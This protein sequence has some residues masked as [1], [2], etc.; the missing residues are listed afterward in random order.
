MYIYRY[1]PGGVGAAA[2]LL[3]AASILSH[4]LAA[5]VISPANDLGAPRRPRVW[6][7]RWHVTRARAVPA[8]CRHSLMP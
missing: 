8:L 3:L 2:S 4:N 6:C 7:W 5:N 1:W